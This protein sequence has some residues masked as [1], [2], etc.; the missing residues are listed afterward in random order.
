MLHRK[1]YINQFNCLILDEVTKVKNN[2]KISRKIKYIAKFR[3]Y[4]IGMTATPAENNLMEFF[5]IFRIVNEEVFKKMTCAQFRDMFTIGNWEDIWNKYLGKKVKVYKIKGYKNID[6]FKDMIRDYYITSDALDIKRDNVIKWFDMDE[7]LKKYYIKIM[8]KYSGK[9]GL[10]MVVELEMLMSGIW[11]DK[12]INEVEGKKVKEIK[13]V[14][15]FK[16]NVKM[17]FIKKAVDLYKSGVVIFSKY[18]GPFGLVKE[19]LGNKFECIDGDLKLEDRAMLQ[20]RFNAGDLEVLGI[21]TAGEKG[22]NLTAGRLFIFLN[23]L[24][25]PAR[26]EQL[27]GRIIRFDNKYKK[28]AIIKLLINRSIDAW[29]ENLIAKKVELFKEFIPKEED[30]KRMLFYEN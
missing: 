1:F 10:D 2:N 16:E 18:K 4:V 11:E 12:I 8:D 22:L 30:W 15:Y 20:N 25:N 29:M 26:N 7:E 9:M 3:N 5:N 23:Q 19:I 17:Q 6:K 13:E 21:T 14:K 27:S 28:V 24:F